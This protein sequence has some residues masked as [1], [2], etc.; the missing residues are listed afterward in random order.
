[1]RPSNKEHVCPHCNMLNDNTNQVGH[2]E[3]VNNNYSFYICAFCWKSFRDTYQDQ[4]Y[5]GANNEGA[6]QS[7]KPNSEESDI[8]K[9][10]I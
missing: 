9:E 6:N 4:I 1:M 2:G 3:V 5:I 10:P 7:P 8:T